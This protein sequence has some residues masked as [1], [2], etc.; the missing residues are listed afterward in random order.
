MQI[1]GSNA[2]SLD[3]IENEVQKL[4]YTAEPIQNRNVR[5]YDVVGMDCSSCAKSIEN[6]LNTIPTVN[7]VTVNFSTGK[8]K[9]EHE[10]S[11]DDIVSEVSKIGFKASLIT[12]SNK[13]TKILRKIKEG[14]GLIPSLVLLIA[15]G[16]IGSYNGVSSFITTISICYCYR[17]KWL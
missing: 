1:I 10:N 17:Y 2:F 5:T 12:N 15:L 7:R 11:V 13:D 3:S 6:H 4:G 14:Y 9:V 8:M 16:F